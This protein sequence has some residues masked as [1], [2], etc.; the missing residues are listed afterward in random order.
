MTPLLLHPRVRRFWGF[1]VVVVIV[2]VVT[3]GK[4]KVTKIPLVTI[5][6]VD[7]SI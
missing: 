5:L 4:I 3:V 2:V 7:R 6:K 1:V